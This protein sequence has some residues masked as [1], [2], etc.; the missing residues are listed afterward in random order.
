M[1]AKFESD[2]EE[3]KVFLNLVLRNKQVRNLETIKW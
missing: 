2:L 1:Q 3:V